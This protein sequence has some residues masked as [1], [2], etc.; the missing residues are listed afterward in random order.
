MT[1]LKDVIQTRL[2]ILTFCEETI[3]KNSKMIL[4]KF[5]YHAMMSKKKYYYYDMLKKMSNFAQ[6]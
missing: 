2:F 6:I 1:F 5:A 4:K 3:I